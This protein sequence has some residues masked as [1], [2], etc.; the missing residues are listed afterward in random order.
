VA[1]RDPR[2]AEDMAR[3]VEMISGAEAAEEYRA[4]AR[5]GCAP[6]ATFAELVQLS[7][8]GADW[9]PARAKAPVGPAAE[10]PPAAVGPPSRRVTAT[11]EWTAPATGRSVGNSADRSGP[12]DVV[13]PDRVERIA[14]HLATWRTRFRPQD[15]DPTEPWRTPQ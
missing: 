2:P 12:E 1:S 8:E 13:V 3:L 14:E 5:A 6:F 15:F 9:P 10:P 4:L 11:A 7:M